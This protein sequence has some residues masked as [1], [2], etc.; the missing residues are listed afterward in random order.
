[1]YFIHLNVFL[2]MKGCMHKW[3]ALILYPCVKYLVSSIPF[4]HH[5]MCKFA[6]LAF[7]NTYVSFWYALLTPAMFLFAQ[8]AKKA[9]AN[10][11]QIN[12]QTIVSR[13][14]PRKRRLNRLIR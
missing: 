10:N 7:D 3:N 6:I 13:M 5:T 8:L 11:M 12:I 14:I 2:I 4:Q 9:G 1:M